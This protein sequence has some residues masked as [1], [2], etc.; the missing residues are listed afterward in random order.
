[1][2]KRQSF[3]PSFSEFIYSELV[4]SKTQHL[5]LVIIPAGSKTDKAKNK[6][7]GTI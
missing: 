7:I 5:S 6:N 1:M 3:Y 4:I 2:L